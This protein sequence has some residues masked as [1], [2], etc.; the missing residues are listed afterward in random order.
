MIEEEFTLDSVLN[1]G[2]LVVSTVYILADIYE[3]EHL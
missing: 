2:N 3:Q 1:F